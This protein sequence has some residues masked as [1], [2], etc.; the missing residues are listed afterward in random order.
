MKREKDTI[1]KESEEHLKI[2]SMK[3]FYLKLTQL[4][5]RSCQYGINQISSY[6]FVEKNRKKA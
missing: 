6:N 3:L 2:L 1:K 5:N 4:I